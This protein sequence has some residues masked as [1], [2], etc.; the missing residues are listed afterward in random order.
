[1][2][3]IE[4]KS[5]PIICVKFFIEKTPKTYKN[6]KNLL[7]SLDL[8]KLQPVQKCITK[9]TLLKGKIFDFFFF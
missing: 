4:P 1:M 3:P 2:C 6:D 7:I 8:F 9:Y 5:V